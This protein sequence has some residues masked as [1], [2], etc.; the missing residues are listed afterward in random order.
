VS[1]KVVISGVGQSAVGRRLGRTGLDLAVDACLAAIADAGLGVADIDGLSTFPGLQS[2]P[3]GYSEVGAQELLTALGLR[4]SWYNGGAETSAQLGSVITGAA[5]VTA[6]L[7][8]HVL[9]FR[10]VTESSG[11]GRG[12]PPAAVGGARQWVAT[13]GRNASNWVGALAQRH[14]HEYGTTRE[15]LGQIAVTHRRHAGLNPAAVYRD[16][17]SLDDYLASRMI[18]TPLCLFDCDVPVDGAT[19]VVLSVPET[20]ADLPHPA[21]LLEST[22]SAIHGP[23]SY[24]QFSRLA[25]SPARHAAQQLWSRTDLRPAE[26]D[27]ACLYDGFSWLTLSWLEALGFCEE[28]GSGAFVEGGGR[29]ALD[30]ELPLNPHGGQL[31]A[32]RTH[33][34]GFLHEACL[35]LRGEAGARQVA[36]SPAVAAVS[37]GSGPFACAMLVRRAG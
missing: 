5:A 36:G 27:V 10:V 26:V 19:A 29:I 3:P 8:R 13:Y 1:G 7:A 20:A 15:Q 18:S 12:A 21:V 34:Y 2:T 28:G 32:G 37:N 25:D 6:G 24:D 23:F 31:S 33:G 35:Q 17:L 16:P 9:C 11:R 4:L 14:F 22:G 30:G